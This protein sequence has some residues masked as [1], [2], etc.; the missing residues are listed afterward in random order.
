MFAFCFSPR[1]GTAAPRL[2]DP[3]PNEV[4]AARLQ[5]LLARQESIQRQ[6]NEALV[7]TRMP[8][9]VTGDGDEPGAY[10]GRTTCH[11]IVHFHSPDFNVSPL[12]TITPVVIEKANPHSLLGRSVE[13]STSP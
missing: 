10:A 7:G 1:P 6:L 4:A 9:L 3:V 13:L 5:I 8:V 12:G 11:R 2:A